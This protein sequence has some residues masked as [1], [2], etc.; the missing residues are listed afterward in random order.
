MTATMKRIGLLGGSFDPLHAGHLQLA[1]DAIAALGLDELRLVVA[2]QPWQKPGVSPAAQR[3]RMVELALD[4]LE[5]SLRARVA[6]ERCELDR[7]GPSYTID[8]LIALRAALGPAPCLALVM[9]SDQWHNLGTWHR[10]AE[11]TDHASIAVA[12]RTDATSAPAG[13]ATHPSAAALRD[14]RYAA[15]PAPGALGTP[16]GQTVS[17]VMTPHPASATA[18]RAQLRAGQAVG[19]DLLPPTVLAYIRAQHLYEKNPA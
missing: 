18:I 1:R 3:L 14:P 16:H 5:P 11:L 9:G 19:P 7:T 8:T 12:R 15:L 13:A 6:I 10:H 2:A 17:F 4:D